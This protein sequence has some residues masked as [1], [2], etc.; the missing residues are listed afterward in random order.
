MI[1]VLNL[2]LIV[3]AAVG[4][5]SCSVKEDRS[6]CPCWADVLF[7]G[8]Y[9]TP[10][11][12]RFVDVQT[13]KLTREFHSIVPDPDGRMYLSEG[14]VPRLEHEIIAF[15]GS[16]NVMVDDMITVPKGHEIDSVSSGCASLD[17]RAESAEAVVVMN[18]QYAGITVKVAGADDSSYPYSFRVIGNTCGITIP[19]GLPVPGPFDYYPR[20]EHG[21]FT[22]NVPRQGD[23]SLELVVIEGLFE[24]D[25]IPL[26]RMILDGGYDWKKASLDRISVEIDY[27]RTSCTVLLSGWVPGVEN[28]RYEI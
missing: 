19:E 22:V 24:I 18:R 13:G 14:E 4:T 3:L 15:C 2:A 6:G 17:T 7:K 16:G 26:G 12:A 23:D 27:S 8:D 1:H 21:R 25:R 11:T 5:G 28:I 20:L 9:C 10:V